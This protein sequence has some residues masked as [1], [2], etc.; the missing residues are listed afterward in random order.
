MAKIFIVED[1]E[2][3]MCII[4]EYLMLA[5]HE[6]VAKAYDGEQ[7]LV[8]FRKLIH[9]LDVIIMD[10][11]MPRKNG[12]AACKEIFDIKPDIIVILVSADFS[13]KDK[14]IKSGVHAFFTK[15]VN[16]DIL[17]AEINKLYIS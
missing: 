14:A 5:G 13:I 9:V 1:N 17:L 6:I 16:Y 3:I 12:L 10:H 15:P 8:V 4:E 11:S 7:A 2:D